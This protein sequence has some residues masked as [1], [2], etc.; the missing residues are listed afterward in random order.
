V[1]A[2]RR[3]VHEPIGA[4]DVDTAVVIDPT[5]T[6]RP[7]RRGAPAS[8]LPSAHVLPQGS[9]VSVDPLR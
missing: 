7:R 1:A 6:Q 9:H 3:A 4:G 2:R 8:R 5:P